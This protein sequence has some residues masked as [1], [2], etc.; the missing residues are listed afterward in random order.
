MNKI[1]LRRDG[2]GNFEVNEELHWNRIVD[3]LEGKYKIRVCNK[4]RSI[5]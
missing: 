1:D 3:I 5:N 2:E 4:Y